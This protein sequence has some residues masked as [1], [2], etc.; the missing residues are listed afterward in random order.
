MPYGKIKTVG[1]STP[2]ELTPEN[3]FKIIDLKVAKMP[4]PIGPFGLESFDSDIARDSSGAAKNRAR[5]SRRSGS[6]GRAPTLNSN[7]RADILAI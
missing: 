3:S 5:F 4:V 1:R 6:G 7:M 2:G